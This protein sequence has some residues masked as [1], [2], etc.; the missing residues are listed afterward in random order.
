MK[1]LRIRSRIVLWELLVVLVLLLAVLLLP[2]CTDDDR[3][4]RIL[5]ASGYT[6]VQLTGWSAFTCSG[7]DVYATGFRAI[8]PTG[9]TVEGTVCCGV[10]KDCTIRIQ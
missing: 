5:E 4:R 8:G 9:V 3:T 10:L 6:H 2:S 7:D 1:R